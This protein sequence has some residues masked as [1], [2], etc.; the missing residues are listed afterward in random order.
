[1]A[2]DLGGEQ[3]HLDVAADPGERHRIAVGLDGDV[4]VRRD[5][6]DDDPFT[7]RRRPQV[8]GDQR[9]GPLVSAPSFVELLNAHRW[10]LAW[11]SGFEVV[12]GVLQPAFYPG[13]FANA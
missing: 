6:A 8:D 5:A 4:A 3:L 1:M 10:R 7:R 9:L 12:I 2:H 13:V 11:V